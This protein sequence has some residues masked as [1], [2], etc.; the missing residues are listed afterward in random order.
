[1]ATIKKIYKNGVEYQMPQ[2]PKGDTGA[3][4]PQGPKGAT[5]VYDQ[6]TQNFLTTLETTTGQSQTKTMTQKAITDAMAAFGASANIDISSLTVQACALGGSSKWYKGSS[7]AAKNASHVAISVSMGE[8]Y[9]LTN[10]SQYQESFAWMTNSYNPPY[11]SGSAMP[12][13]NLTD[14]IFVPIGETVVITPPEGAAFLVLTN[15]DGG[16]G[17][18]DWNLVKSMSNN[19][20]ERF[21]Q[22]AEADFIPTSIDVK[23][24]ALLG[25]IIKISDPTVTDY[26]ERY[27]ARIVAAAPFLGKRLRIDYGA[28]PTMCRYAF[29]SGNIIRQSGSTVPY[30][31]GETLR[32]GV[33]DGILP[34][35]CK[36]IYFYDNSDGTNVAPSFT[37]FEPVGKI[38]VYDG[39]TKVN[40]SN[41]TKQ[42]CSLG[43]YNWYM[44]SS[45]LQRH[46]A[47]PVNPGETYKIITDTAAC[48]YAI[49]NSSYNPPYTSGAQIPFAS[50]NDMRSSCYGV[51]YVTIPSDGAYL[52]LTTTDGANYSPNISLYKVNKSWQSPNSAP[53]DVPVK[54]RVMQWNVGHWAMGTSYTSNLTP[55][56]FA[57]KKMKYRQMLNNANADII[58]CCE[59]SENVVNA[60]SGYDAMKARD[61]LFCQYAHQD[62]GTLSSATSYMRT[63]H[64]SNMPPVAMKET[65][66]NDTVAAGRYFHTVDFKI[67]GKIIKVVATHLDWNQ[68]EHGAEY[69]QSQMEQL[70]STFANEKYVI[71]CA[72]WNCDESEFDQFITAGYQMANHGYLGDL[73]TYDSASEGR[74]MALDNIICKGFMVSDIEV[75]DEEYELSDHRPIAATFTMI[76]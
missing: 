6:T 50:C 71:I 8:R 19:T 61:E 60:G 13:V 32:Q 11:S 20:G 26:S 34:E 17:Q 30:C 23:S 22:L 72:D 38:P 68:G 54:F 62:V 66:Y 57:A 36:F 45:N 25:N 43:T 53:K 59:W 28:S 33:F 73:P 58:C 14:R 44:A 49:V 24:H 65:V 16:G 35:D 2:G 70:I 75:Y 51:S 55:E 18:C 52:I 3:T 12:I 5:S 46:I 1:M 4:G 56:T 40:I 31:K 64:F 76:E 42:N 67:N 7:G 29:L 48:L 15:I 74:G 21:G 10:N 9:I 27:T 37:V 69:R 47:V 41:L 63:S 39:E